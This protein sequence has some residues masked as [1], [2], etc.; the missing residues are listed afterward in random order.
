MESQS[1][2]KPHLQSDNTKQ[3]QGILGSL[4]YHNF[5][6]VLVFLTTGS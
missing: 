1:V 5:L 2:Y 3:V 4:L 6:S